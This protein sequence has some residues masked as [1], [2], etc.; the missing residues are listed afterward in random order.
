MS[1]NKEVFRSFGALKGFHDQQAEQ[2]E[3]KERED[4]KEL[5]DQ[6]LK[7]N[8][9]QVQAASFAVPELGAAGQVAFGRQENT[10]K[11][12]NSLWIRAAYQSQ[13]EKSVR[14]SMVD[15]FISE[16]DA[17]G[18]ISAKLPKNF[19]LSRADFSRLV[20]GRIESMNLAKLHVTDLVAFSRPDI[21]RSTGEAEQ[22]E[23]VSM[24]HE[25]DPERQ[26]QFAIL[27]S[28]KG[29][30]FEAIDRG[31]QEGNTMRYPYNG[32]H[33]FVYR[34]GF[35]LEGP[36]KGYA[37]YFLKFS[38]PMDIERDPGMYDKREEVI[39]KGVRSYLRQAESRRD[40]LKKFNASRVVHEGNWQQRVQ[41]KTRELSGFQ[42]QI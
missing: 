25:I 33:V 4:V 26:E 1:E 16:R 18:Y 29:F 9:D 5:Y 10:K 15:G 11:G 22:S 36:E 32:Y 42:Q 19:P 3:A 39:E 8:F 30:L 31:Q 20:L 41:E 14:Q 28:V 38:N 37:A 17:T 12:E 6:S 35:C 7:D 2:A 34:G 27:R 23:R 21:I 13:A 40:L 24:E